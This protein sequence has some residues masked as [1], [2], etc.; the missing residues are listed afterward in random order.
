MQ[1]CEYKNTERIWKQKERI[2][3]IFQNL[4]KFHNILDVLDIEEK[5]I[6]RYPLLK[7]GV[8]GAHKLIICMLQLFLNNC[9][10][11]RA[12]QTLPASSIHL[13]T[14]WILQ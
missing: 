6:L 12:A 4:A 7:G 8:V 3:N 5:V 9:V 10:K 14:F 13:G 2:A 1:I 11:M